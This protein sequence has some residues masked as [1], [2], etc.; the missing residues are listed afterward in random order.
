MQVQCGKD[1]RRIRM[2]I[3]DRDLFDPNPKTPEHTSWTMSLLNRLDGTLGDTVMERPMFSFGDPQSLPEGHPD[4]I[5]G[6]IQRGKY[7][8]FFAK[9]P[10]KLSQLAHDALI[11]PPIPTVELLS[12][13]PFRPIAFEPPAYPLLA[14]AARVEGDVSFT[15]DLN[16]DGTAENLRILSGPALLRATV[17]QTVARWKFPEGAAGLEIQATLR[18]KTNCPAA[19]P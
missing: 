9:A 11:P 10:D 6:D 17:E 13:S 16:A 12:S 4:R 5:V 8:G 14:K 1:L 15:L 19:H 18:F 7:D 2:D 3:L